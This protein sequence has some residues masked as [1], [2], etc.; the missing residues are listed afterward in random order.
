MLACY[1][2]PDPDDEIGW[3]LL[4]RAIKEY[5]ECEHADVKLVKRR[6]IQLLLLY[7]WRDVF[8]ENVLRSQSGPPDRLLTNFN[9]RA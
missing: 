3:S 1:T 9:S 6:S 7:G 4:K 8:K 2:F 5:K